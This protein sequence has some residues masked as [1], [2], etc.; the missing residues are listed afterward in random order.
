MIRKT[1]LGMLGGLA[2]M[3]SV[4]GAA[5][6]DPAWG[7]NYHGGR[8]GNGVSVSVGNGYPVYPA[9]V[10]PAPAYY[11]PAAYYPPPAY[12]APSSVVVQGYWDQWHH[13]H[14]YHRGYY[15]HW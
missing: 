14:R 5:Q 15:R 9:P 7:I 6:A 12:V 1:L 2:L 10:Y 4:A 3:A 11:P 8:W 13:W